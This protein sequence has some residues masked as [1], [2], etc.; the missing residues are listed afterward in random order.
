MRK[1]KILFTDF[2]GTLLTDEKKV[3]SENKAALKKAQEKGHYLAFTTGRPLH[4][5]RQLFRAAGISPEQCFLICYQGAMVYDLKEERILLQSPMEEES[6]FQVLR[7]VK[8]QNLYV[9][10]FDAERLYC[11]DV[12][13][14]TR[15]YN[16]LTK[17]DYE[18]ISDPKQLRETSVLKVMAIDYH[19]RETLEQL[20][21]CV[22]EKRL[23][24]E[25]FFT[26]PWFYEFCG[27]GVNKGSG[28]SFLTGYLGIPPENTIA[29]GDEENDIP[30]IEQAGV[31]IVM[32]NA[33]D[34]IKRYG[35]A[36]T[37]RNNNQSGV[38]EVIYHYMLSGQETV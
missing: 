30:M 12:T 36:V 29:V 2:D 8:E 17:E 5:A 38:A 4:G 37:A 21:L 27:R 34:E 33:R 3:T 20:D 13:E 31:G 19:S 23:L 6:L 26:S 16:A 15:R 32:K 14:E 11:F 7:E 22:K 10:C 25:S 1:T 28:L 18:V 35:N 9:Q 24:V